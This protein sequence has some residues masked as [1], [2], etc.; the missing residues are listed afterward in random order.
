[1]PGTL[2]ERGDRIAMD[3]AKA[4][5]LYQ[6]ACDANNASGCSYLGYAY[7]EGRGV[8]VDKAH[9]LELVK[10]GCDGGSPRGCNNIAFAYEKGTMV[11]KDLK[12]AEELYQGACD[13]KDGLAC[14]N[15]GRLAALGRASARAT[16]RRARVCSF[17]KR[18]RL[19]KSSLA[20]ARLADDDAARRGR[21]EGSR[22]SREALRRPVR[23]RK[24]RV[25]REPRLPLER[26]AQGVEEGSAARRQAPRSARGDGKIARACNNL[27]NGD[28]EFEA[29]RADRR[30]PRRGRHALQKSVRP[31]RA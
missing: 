15:L 23:R 17:K 27:G 31:R 24:P 2:Y 16:T 9:A 1:M 20:C 3:L 13:K 7:S 28:R 12:R 21:P 18:L 14:E 22:D 30:R 5:E 19:R 26:R 6:K 8:A 10:K 11:A 4:A 29:R 25:V